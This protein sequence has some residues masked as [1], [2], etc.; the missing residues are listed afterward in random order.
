MGG[1]HLWAWD[2]FCVVAMAATA[3]TVP[4]LDVAFGEALEKIPLARVNDSAKPRTGTETSPTPSFDVSFGALITSDYN[5]RGY[6]LSNHQPSVSSYFEAT[7]DILFAGAY[8]SSVSFPG[9]P[10]LQMTYSAGVRPVF[11]PVTVEVG[12]GYYNYPGSHGIIDYPEY[13][14]RPSYV[15]S[16]KLTLGLNV[17]YAP[18]YIRSGAWENYI[19]GTAKYAITDALSISG[20]IGRQLYGTTNATPEIPAIALPDYT[21][22][23]FGFS[24]KY[25]FVTVDIRFHNNTLSKQRCFLITGTGDPVSGSNGCGSAV[26]GTISLDSTLSALKTTMAAEK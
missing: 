15:V 17:Y 2:L 4:Q 12:V 20:E 6:T 23:N 8:A 21:Y 3:A 18:D 9:V 16:S 14:L 1:V 5:Y 11:G 22:W 10:S 7:Y 24:Y 13:Y 26:I 25:D 19:S